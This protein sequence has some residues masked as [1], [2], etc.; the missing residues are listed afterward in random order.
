MIPGKA[1]GCACERAQT[2]L[3]TRGSHMQSRNLAQCTLLASLVF[4]DVY[5]AAQH[6][7]HFSCACGH[8][9]NK[10]CLAGHLRE[11]L[12]SC[13]DLI[14]AVHIALTASM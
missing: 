4:G 9:R 10:V 8:T 5:T 3:L 13:W 12:C 11:H 7:W 6:P 14:A 1:Q 2:V